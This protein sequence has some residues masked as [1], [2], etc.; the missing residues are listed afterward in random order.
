MQENYN[1]YWKKQSLQQNIIFPT[2]IIIHPSFDVVI[3]TYVQDIPKTVVNRF[4]ANKSIQRHPVFIID[5]DGD[6]ILDGIECR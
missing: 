4:Q 2:L 1:W 6:Y 5:D 3:I